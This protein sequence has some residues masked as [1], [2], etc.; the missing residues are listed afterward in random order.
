MKQGRVGMSDW[1]VQLAPKCEAMFHDL[2]Y[3][4]PTGTLICTRC[5]ATLDEVRKQSGYEPLKDGNP[6]YARGGDCGL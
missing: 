2:N 4:T 6:N 5:G 3:V 1:N